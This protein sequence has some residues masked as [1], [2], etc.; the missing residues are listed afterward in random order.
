MKIGI[1]SDIHSNIE[2]LDVV[3]KRFESEKVDQIF[4]LGDIIG[5]G[6]NPNECVDRVRSLCTVSVLGNHDAALTGHTPIH[7]FNSYARAAIEWTHRVISDSNMEFLKGLPLIYA[8][9]HCLLVHAT[10]VNPAAWDYIHSDADAEAHFTAM[11][12]KKIAFIGHSHLPR[13][14]EMSATGKAN[15]EYRFRRPT[16]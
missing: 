12:D 5:Y 6:P 10:P 13:C 4:C 11:N 8:S 15:R 1:I 14:Y 9:E 7:Y 16:A 3:I 2:A